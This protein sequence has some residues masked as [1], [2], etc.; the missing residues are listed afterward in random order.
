MWHQE[1]IND[2]VHSHTCKT[3]VRT[4]SPV[5]DIHPSIHPD[6]DFVNPRQPMLI[7]YRNRHVWGILV[8]A[9]LIPLVLSSPPISILYLMPISLCNISAD[10]CTM[11]EKH[12]RK[13][14]HPLSYIFLFN[15]DTYSVKRNTHWHVQIQC[16][17]RCQWLTSVILF[18]LSS[19]WGGLSDKIYT[20]NIL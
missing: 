11:R 3:M 6:W 9:S 20:K 5:I 4:E 2:N 18:S 10:V 1:M 16:F 15:R 13:S 19:A 12:W 7:L 8:I 17:N 14:E